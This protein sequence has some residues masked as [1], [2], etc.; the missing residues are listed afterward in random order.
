V[1]EIIKK[2]V[3]KTYGFLDVSLSQTGY[4]IGLSDKQGYYKTEYYIMS[5]EKHKLFKRLLNEQLMQFSLNKIK[6]FFLGILK[7]NKN[8]LFGHPVKITKDNKVEFEFYNKNNKK[9]NN[10]FAQVEIKPNNFFSNEFKEELFKYDSEGFLFYIPKREKIK[11]KN[12]RFEVKAIR[13]HEQVVR[14]KINSI[15]NKLK[16]L[17]KSYGYNKCIIDLKR[18]RVTLFVKMYFSKKIQDFFKEEL[19]ELDDFEIIYIN[20]TKNT[21][22]RKFNGKT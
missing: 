18:K 3:S 21:K 4:F 2:A 22:T 6:T 15:F 14:H 17:G 11:Q 19:A 20:D 5:N 13:V 1:R 9:I 10:F 16:E 7:A 12:G 8:I